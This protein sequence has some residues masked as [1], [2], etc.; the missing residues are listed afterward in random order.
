M[1]QTLSIAIAGAGIGGL[2]SACLLADQGHRVTVFDRFPAPRPVGSGLVIQPVGLSVLAAIGLADAALALG[3]PLSRLFGHTPGGRPVL[4]VSYA[5][6]TGLGIHRASLFSLLWDAARARAIPIDQGAEIT[7]R[8]GSRL[9]IGMRV[10]DP[11][12]LIIDAAGAH[13]PLSPLRARPLAYGALWTTV[14]WPATDLPQDELRQRYRAAARMIG[15]LPIGR[16]PGD[17]APKAALFWSLR[18]GDHHE[19]LTQGLAPWKAEAE[20]LWPAAA[21]FLAKVTDP[22]QMTLARYGHG[23]LR[24]PYADHIVHIG[25]AAHR[26]SPQLGQGANMALLDAQALALA[27][28]HADA[29]NPLA[30]YAQARRAHVALYQSFSALFTPQ[31][32]SDSRALPWLRDRLLFPLSQISPLPRVLTRLVCGHLVPPLGSLDRR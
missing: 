17:P 30:L 22:A 16:L 15:I 4:D 20:A 31:Y 21:P 6:R 24:R 9:C 2:A 7:G 11:F 5:P 13:S 25:D 3:Q 14:D 32:Q 1:R 28:R 23:T 12:D 8:D 10:T 27:L 19:W 18:V 29:Q 26:A